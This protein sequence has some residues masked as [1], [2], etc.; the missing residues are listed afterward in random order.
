[1]NDSLRNASSTPP[2]P[3]E[4]IPVWP[5]EAPSA[6]WW[7]DP[8]RP[9]L[10]PE[11]PRKPAPGPLCQRYHDGARWTPYISY[12]VERRVSPTG[13]SPVAQ[14][15]E[16]LGGP[17]PPLI[18]RS[19]DN[20]DFLPESSFIRFDPPDPIVSGWWEDPFSSFGQQRYHDGVRW[21][22]YTVH[23]PLRGAVTRSEIPAVARPAPA[24]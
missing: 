21:T 3:P 15:P 5:P 19:I 9:G 13:W 1:M 7:T 2:L 22:Q 20:Y 8:Y 10:D 17:A 4:D 11:D 12:R 23:Y 24:N 16:P 6:G 18:P 14:D